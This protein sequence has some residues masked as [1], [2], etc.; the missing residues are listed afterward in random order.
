MIRQDYLGMLHIY[1]PSQYA[2][3]LSNAQ[4][5]SATAIPPLYQVQLYVLVNAI[6]AI[7]PPDTTLQA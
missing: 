3:G 2:S 7:P 5:P 1:H 6:E 4:T